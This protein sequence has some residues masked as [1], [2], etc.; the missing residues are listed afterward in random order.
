M[1]AM[2]SGS[3]RFG[4]DFVLAAAGLLVLL[5]GCGSS[6][7]PRAIQAPPPQPA[8]GSSATGSAASA[9]A[10]VTTATS[11]AAFRND[12]VASTQQMDKVLAA[13]NQLTD[14]NTQDLRGAYDNYSDQLARMNQFAEK[15]KGEAT[16]M[17]AARNQYF[18][19]WEQRLSEINNPNIRASVEARQAKLRASHDRIRTETLDARDAYEPFMRD[20]R[21]ARTFLGGDLSKQSTSMLGQFKPKRRP[22]VPI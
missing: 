5:V 12:L 22:T 21:D 4:S 1:N 8:A 10:Q 16:A 9:S 6:D 18:A 7:K 13:L 19:T 11:A 20:L 15:L 14:P 17:G 3:T 2:P